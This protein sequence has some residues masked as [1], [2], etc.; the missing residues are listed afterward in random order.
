VGARAGARGLWSVWGEGGT[1]TPATVTVDADRT[2]VMIDIESLAD[3]DTA[4]SAPCRHNEI[5]WPVIR[6]LEQFGSTWNAGFRAGG[7]N[8]RL[9]AYVDDGG[10]AR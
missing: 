4:T 2:F 1:P 8:D 3:I 5:R 7:S 10:P 6:T 9:R